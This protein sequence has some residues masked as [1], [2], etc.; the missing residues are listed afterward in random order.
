MGGMKIQNPEL[1]NF[2][3]IDRNHVP[4]AVLALAGVF[5]RRRESRGTR[6]IQK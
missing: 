5:H 3:C 2:S 1:G 4:L 6:R